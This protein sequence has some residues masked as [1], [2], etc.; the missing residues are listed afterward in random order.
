[1]PITFANEAAFV[2]QLAALVPDMKGG[3][4]EADFVQEA[5]RVLSEDVPA[6]EEV[7]VGDGTTKAWT[8]GASP[9]GGWA[10]GFSD[11]WPVTFEVLDE[12]GLPFEPP[13]DYTPAP[14][15]VER[16]VSANPAHVLSF[17]D[18]PATT[19]KCRVRFRKPWT[20]AAGST[21]VPAHL[22]LAVVKKAAAK[23]CAALATFY[24]STIDPAGGSDIFDA[25][26]YAEGYAADAKRWNAEYADLVGLGPNETG[27]VS[28]TIRRG[29]ATAF[30]P[31]GS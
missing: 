29:Q 19:A 15:I 30:R 2:A 31:R 13:V 12:D 11:L 22:Q 5:V 10:A 14:R 28:G 27:F 23:K 26:M 16:T 4:A 18:A 6:W 25:R 21:N 9:F 3:Y 1:M 20:I 24:R 8:L 7:D 17:R